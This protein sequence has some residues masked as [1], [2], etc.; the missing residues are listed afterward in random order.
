MPV[1]EHVAPRNSF[2]ATSYFRKQTKGSTNFVSE[3][4]ESVARTKSVLTGN[5]IAMVTGTAAK[6]TTT[7]SPSSGLFLDA[8][9]AASTDKERKRA[10]RKMMKP[11]PAAPS[12]TSFTMEPYG[13]HFPQLL[14]VPV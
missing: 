11:L 13:D 7:C 10:G 2:E 14:S 4:L 1:S 5:A 8:I 6:M 12:Y 9:F 3:L